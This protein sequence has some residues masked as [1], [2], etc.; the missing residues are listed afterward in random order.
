MKI[1]AV[2][3]KFMKEFIIRDLGCFLVEDF[4]M[5]LESALRAVYNSKTYELLCNPETGFY[6][7][8][9]KYVYGYLKE[10]I[11]TGKFN[12]NPRYD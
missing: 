1:S 3:F 10:E 12:P 7:Q 9:P 5:T 4:G 11:A 6:F 2:D 8:S